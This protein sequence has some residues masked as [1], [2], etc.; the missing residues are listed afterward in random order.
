ME[1]TLLS[2]QWTSPHRGIISPFQSLQPT[3]T[4]LKTKRER[5][6]SRSR[7]TNPTNKITAAKRRATRNDEKE[8][9]ESRFRRLEQMVGSGGGRYNI[10]HVDWCR[11]LIHGSCRI[12]EA[13]KANWVLKILE[14]SGYVPD[15]I[16]YTVVI[17][18]CCKDG[19]STRRSR[20]L[21]A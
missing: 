5:S 6:I 8:E 18:G 21:T 9:M 2:L 17:K 4:N 16:T 20:C 10:P 1:T 19:M 14:D 11:E 13:S 7:P 12:G 3:N 15:V